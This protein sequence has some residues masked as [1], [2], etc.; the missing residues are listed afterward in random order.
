MTDEP[1]QL[2]TIQRLLYHYTFASG[3]LCV[4][5]GPDNPPALD[6]QNLLHTVETPW[7]PSTAT[8]HYVCVNHCGLDVLVPQRLLHCLGVGWPGGVSDLAAGAASVPELARVPVPQKKAQIE[9][10]RRVAQGPRDRW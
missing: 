6:W 1:Q 8:V 5:L 10:C 4:P 7:N 9:A 2:P 3:I